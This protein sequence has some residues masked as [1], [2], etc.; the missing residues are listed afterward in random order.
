MKHTEEVDMNADG[1]T[2]AR[3]ENWGLMLHLAKTV[4]TLIKRFI[5]ERQFFQCEITKLG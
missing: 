1:Q 4:I 3:T 2:K 5:G